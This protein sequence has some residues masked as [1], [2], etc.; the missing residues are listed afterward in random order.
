MIDLNSN[1]KIANSKI[2]DLEQT[3]KDLSE[4]AN[5]QNDRMSSTEKEH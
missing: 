2:S 1:L 5:L 3:N 4:S